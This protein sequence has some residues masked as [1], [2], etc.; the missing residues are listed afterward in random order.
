MYNAMDGFCQVEQLA[1][2]ADG[3]IGCGEEARGGCLFTWNFSVTRITVLTE[4]E[5]R[6]RTSTSDS[7]LAYRLKIPVPKNRT[8]HCTSR[9][10][11]GK[12]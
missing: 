7:L 8:R 10:V 11:T 2:L 1:E 6:T 3:H 4:A 5:R 9:A 12:T